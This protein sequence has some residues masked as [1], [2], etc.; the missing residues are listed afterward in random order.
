MTRIRLILTFLLIG[1]TVP[2]AQ[3]WIWY[4]GDFEIS[5]ANKVQNRRTEKGTFF[6][7]FWK[8]DNHY[9]L[10][11]FHKV[12]DLTKAEKV[13]IHVEGEYNV[14]LDGK[15]FEGSPS[16]I[17]V[18][19]G[20][21]KIN[22]KVF[23]QA[24]VPAIFVSGQTIKSDNSWLVTFEDKEWI[25]E[26]G[27]TS[28]ISATRWLKA[29]T[30]NFNRPEDR[31]SRFM[32]PVKPMAPAKLE[33]RANGWLADFGRETFG[34]V[35]LHGVKGSGR[36]T[37]YYG[38]SKEE[39]LSDEH[40]ETYDPLSVT[41]K[42]GE[43][44]TM[45]LSKAFRYV[46]VKQGPGV[47]V[48]SLSMRFEY[49][50]V[51]ERGSFTCS[52]PEINRIY[53]VSRY[54]FH[55]NT[56]EFFIDGIK[57]DRWVWSGDAYQSYLMNYYSYFDNAT[58]E[59]T[60]LALRGKDPVTAHINTIM[61][62]T[63][64]WFLGI[65]DYYL[66]TGDK[67]FIGQHYDRMRSLMD[68]VLSR[69][70]HDGLLEWMPGDWI[71][72]DWAAG[73]S[74][75]GEVSFEQLLFARSLETMA[76]CA[77]IAGDPTGADQ[78]RK[79]S[80]E[81]KQKLFQI[82]WNQEKQALVHSRVDGKQTD[83]VTRYAN[84]FSIFFGYFNEE[85]R[86]AVKTSVLLNDKVQRITTPYMRF[87]ELEAL[88]ALGEQS[89][90]LKEMKDYWGGM[91]K[92]GATS[93]W[94]EYNPMKSGLDHYSMYGR[95]FGKSLCHAWGASPIYLLGKYYLGVRPLTAGYDT[96][97]AEPS[98]GGLEWMKGKVPTPAGD[99]DMEVSRT[100]IR[101]TGVTGTGILRFKSS[102]RPESTG[103]ILEPKG[104]DLYEVKIKSGKTVDI[105]YKSVL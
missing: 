55:L 74:K 79:L 17:D 89:F 13:R 18:P 31:P 87:Y 4:P 9:V 81:L 61:D 11:D 20:R 73:L 54:T 60:M 49:A 103:G 26:T 35:T 27:K 16:E 62:Y 24:E 30:W 105:T 36:I 1:P 70:N 95:T 32:L 28:D 41:N 23:N 82:Y 22:I 77:E 64:Y 5:L 45:A 85:Q 8:M 37:V 51:K 3:T 10:M 38:E 44:M 66:Y 84:M 72:I 12:F 100:R 99:I 33:R 52:D 94:E 59:R 101:I 76:L 34:F 65:Y 42:R 6:P 29:G 40:C 102:M 53:D 50:D 93:F 75:K 47:S 21:H 39:A 90:V 15:P 83:N 46:R 88:C 43:D 25:D 91:L 96:W 7:V 56:R 80:E 19:A 68:Y 86:K 98:L 104:G 71:F 48:D 78:Y 67:R 69:R 63:L 97:I 58:V 14:K 92:L 57:R 2:S